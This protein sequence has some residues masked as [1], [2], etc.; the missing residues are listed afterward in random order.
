[1]AAS[2]DAGLMAAVSDYACSV[3]GC[4]SERI[5]AVARF[6]EGNRHA[7]HRVSYLDAG[8]V[9]QDV[10]VRVS[11]GG[12]AADCAQA[13]RE[14]AALQ[15]VAGVAGPVV[16]DV[17]LRSQWFQAPAMCLQFLPGRQRKLRSST[18]AEIGRLASIVAWVH[19]RATEDLVQ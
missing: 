3:V 8:G 14:A 1:M 19:E 10:V 4:R 15:T 7:V 12:E 18:R 2:G 17:R 11:F 6:A 16:Y 13:A 5:I 9:A